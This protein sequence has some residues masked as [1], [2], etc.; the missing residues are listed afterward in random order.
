MVQSIKR[1]T[2]LVFCTFKGLIVL[3][4]DA[5]IKPYLYHLTF[6]KEYQNDIKIRYTQTNMGLLN[7]PPYIFTIVS[8]T[9]IFATVNMQIF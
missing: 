8:P 4:Y 1:S 5:K 6:L 3:C 2:F 7:Q 9:A